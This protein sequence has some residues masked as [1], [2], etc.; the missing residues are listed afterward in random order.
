M[1][2]AGITDYWTHAFRAESLYSA[3]DSLSFSINPALDE[4]RVLM[5]L[6]TTTGHTWASMT[7]QLAEHLGLSPDTRLSAPELRQ[8]IADAGL[9]LHG[10]D[11][12]FYLAQTENEPQMAARSTASVRQ[13]QSVDAAAFAVFRAA[14]SEEDFDAAYV[15][16]DHWAAF[17]AFVGPNLVCAASAYPWGGASIADL[18]V[19]TLPEFRGQGH[20][21]HVVRALCHHALTQ[22]YEPQYRCQLDNAASIALARSAGFTRFGSWDVI[23]AQ[24]DV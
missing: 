12:L 15:E 17:G 10:E 1:F 3:D 18:G 16:L 5:L 23:P 2:P 9:C 22:G 7:P 8:R 6:Q 14:V 13:L 21:R 24:Q 4:A 11:G 20:A 19:L